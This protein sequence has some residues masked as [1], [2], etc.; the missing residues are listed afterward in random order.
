MATIDAAILAM[1]LSACKARQGDAWRI[2]NRSLSSPCDGGLNRR[3]VPDS[4]DQR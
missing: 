3:S 2:A 1:P 4:H